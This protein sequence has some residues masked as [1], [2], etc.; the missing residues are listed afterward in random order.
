VR[1]EHK[2]EA[3]TAAILRAW[4]AAPDGTDMSEGGRIIAALTVAFEV[5]GLTMGGKLTDKA[6]GLLR[7]VDARARAAAKKGGAS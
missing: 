7:R 2:G 6:R 3:A 1:R 4:N 5:E